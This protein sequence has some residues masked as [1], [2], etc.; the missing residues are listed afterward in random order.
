MKI[1]ITGGNGF[2][3]RNISERLGNKHD[4]INQNR[5]DLDLFDSQAVSGFLNSNRFDA[6][7]HTATYD[8]VPKHSGKDP[9]R[10]LEYNLR[11]FINIANCSASF[12]RMLY[13]GS[14][15]EFSREHWNP[16]MKEDYFGSYIPQDQYGF[17]KFIMNEY[18]RSSGNIYNLR[19]F[20][21]FGRYEDWRVR[22]ISNACCY[23]VLGLPVPV[24]H[25]K[26]FDFL[27]I[28][29]LVNITDWFI[30]NDPRHHD[31][32]ICTGKSFS[33]LDLAERIIRIS[34]KKLEI[35]LKDK[36]PQA[37]YSGDNS[38]FLNE[39]GGY[40]FKEMDAALTELYEWYSS[41]REIIDK[42]KLFAEA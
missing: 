24:N 5:R 13:Y 31:Y 9:A 7:I 41:N 1:L 16:G 26:R 39:S 4:I 21:V 30:K 6:V 11:M 37:V 15:A 32:N 33:F 34:G 40:S 27:Y 28:D 22:F 36:T 8:A 17:S 18:A 38:R 2:I 29:D 25:N 14:G 20:G 12:G 3:A 23:A 19:L 35:R 10:V 42:D